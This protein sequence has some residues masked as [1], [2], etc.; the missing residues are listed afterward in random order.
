M[1][2]PLVKVCGMTRMEDVKLCVDLGVDL[3]GF[4]FHPRSPRNADPDFV[5]S[6]K[7]GKVTKV[8]VFVDQTA[9]EVIEIMDRCGLHAA[10]LH[11]GQDSVYC[12]KIG[13]DRVIRVFWPDTYGSPGALVRDLEDYAEVC[14][15]FLL[16]AGTKGQ[17]GTGKSINLKIL[18]DI[19]IQT[20]WFLAGGLGPD[21]VRQALAVNP[22][23]LDFNSGVE[24]A[25]GIKDPAKLREVFR[26]L[27]E[28]E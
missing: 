19:E 10:Q 16:D 17:G 6:V 3:L 21:N 12:W 15:H 23:G 2:R 13:P 1:Q 25:P 24:S 7:T 8:G 14:G 5:A 11:G 9:D 20:P 26:I 18:Q 28:M 27:A 4:I 22:S